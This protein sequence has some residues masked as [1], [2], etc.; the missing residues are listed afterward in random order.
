MFRGFCSGIGDLAHASNAK[1]RSISPENFTGEKGKGAMATEGTG[2]QCARELGRGWKISPSIV[3]KAGE[4]FELANIKGSGAIK[5]I[6]IT[7]AARAGRQLVLRMYWDGCPVAS[8]ETPLGDFFAN[9]D[10]TDYRQLSS[11]AVCCNPKRGLNCYWEMPFRSSCRITLE[12]IYTEDITV[13]YQIDY[14]LSEVDDDCMYFHARFRRSNPLPY[15]EVHT[16]LDGVSG[17]G[18]YVGTYLYWGVHNNGW[19]GEGEIKFY[20]DG[21]KEFPTICGT[22]TEDYICGAYN[23]DVDGKYVEFSTPYSGLYKVSRPDGLY[24]SQ[25]RFSMYR[26]HVVDPIYFREDIRVTIQALGWRS[27]GR[28]LPLMDDIS[29]VAF[30][31]QTQPQKTPQG[32]PDYNGLEIN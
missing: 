8:V 15:Q 32:L 19:W 1:S 10:Y 2:K 31:Y 3:I 17:Q 14:I 18:A 6:W 9:A 30:W 11:L 21:D 24:Q 29:S 12:N 20:L 16:L 7:D 23:F 4:T 26:W 13:Y 28:Y 22:G 27:G 5:H 25:Q